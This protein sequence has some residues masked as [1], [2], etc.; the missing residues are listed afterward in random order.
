MPRIIVWC[1]WCG[2]YLRSIDGKGQSGDSH[3]MCPECY[4]E[5]IEKLDA[6]TNKK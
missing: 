3:G 2:K 4:K 5:E 1:A 6:N